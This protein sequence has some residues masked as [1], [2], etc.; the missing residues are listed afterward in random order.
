MGTAGGKVARVFG[1]REREGEAATRGKRV[2]EARTR[3]EMKEVGVGEHGRRV[4]SPT[5]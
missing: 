1:E 4:R 5:A 2:K 3:T